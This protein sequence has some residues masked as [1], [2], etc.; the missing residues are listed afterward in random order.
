MKTDNL[1]A[2]IDE[3]GP[4]QVLTIDAVKREFRGP[5]IIRSPL[6]IEGCGATIWAATS[7]ARVHSSASQAV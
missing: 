5:L 3:L 7:N 4:G 6:S 2:R 1:Q